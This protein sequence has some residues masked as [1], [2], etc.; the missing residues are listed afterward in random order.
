MLFS[1]TK[2]HFK[3]W[4]LIEVDDLLDY[5][6]TDQYNGKYPYVWLK[7]KEIEVR[8]DFDWSWYPA[9]DQVNLVHCFPQCSM[10]T[11]RPTSWNVLKLVSTNPKL[12]KRENKQPKIAS[13]YNDV[14]DIFFFTKDTT[15]YNL[16]F[17]R[18]KQKFPAAKIITNYVSLEDTLLSIKPKHN[19]IY[20]FNIDVDVNYD[21]D[22]GMNLS[23]DC[24][25]HLTLDHRSN[26]MKYPDTNAYAFTADFLESFKKDQSELL[27]VESKHCPG[28]MN[29]YANPLN[30]WMSSYITTCLLLSDYIKPA[31]HKN[32]ILTE[33]ISYDVN[34][35]DLYVKDGCETAVSD[36]EKDHKIANKVE[37]VKFIVERFKERQQEKQNAIVNP[38]AQAARLRAQYGDTS[39]QYM[40]ALKSI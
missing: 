16:K 12:R 28:I 37:N 30:A 11:K 40:D 32:K 38:I 35:L 9:D 36:Y 17:L 39:D 5:S 25:Y 10:L 19:L 29:D 23:D 3:R 13:W 6:V 34:R 31:M 18:A 22:F 14:C 20:L 26:G 15:P 33:F 4:P 1:F 21:F 24:L 8:E 2:S 7:N 27:L